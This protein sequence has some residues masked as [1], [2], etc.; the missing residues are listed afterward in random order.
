MSA[1]NGKRPTKRSP[2]GNRTPPAAPAERSPEPDVAPAERGAAV[3]DDSP[4]ADEPTILATI[5]ASKRLTTFARVA[6]LAGVEELFRTAGWSTVFAP[7]DRAFELLGVNLAAL[8]ADRD[9]LVAL[10]RRHVFPARVTAP[11]P[12]APMRITALG[13]SARELTAH[14]GG[15]RLGNARVVRTNIRAS[16]GVVHVIDAVLAGP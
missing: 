2:A 4:Y 8:L 11:R 9:A 5:A 6:H 7:S 16:N 12:G 13:G 10:V 1:R 15:Y 3:R 14:D